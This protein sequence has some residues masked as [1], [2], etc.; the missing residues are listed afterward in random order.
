MGICRYRIATLT[1][2]NKVISAKVGIHKIFFKMFKH[3]IIQLAL[4][5]TRS[6]VLYGPV[7]QTILC[8]KRASVN[9]KILAKIWNKDLSCKFMN[10]A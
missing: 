1:G 6:M 9:L 8:N 10:F 2:T 3:M 5:S 7:N 4:D